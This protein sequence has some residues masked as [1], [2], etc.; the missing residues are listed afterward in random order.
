VAEVLR[1]VGPVRLLLE[2]DAKVEV[3]KRALRSTR[4]LHL[5]SHATFQP[6]NPRF[7]W[8]RLEDDRLTVADLYEVSLPLRP[9]VFMSACETGRG[10]AHGGG[11]L[12][13]SR[14]LLA[15][16]A[17]GL[18]VSLWKVADL[19]ASRLSADFYQALDPWQMSEGT[20]RALQQAQQAAISRHEHP[21]LWSAFIYV[22]G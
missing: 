1:R 12:G 7:S 4:L 22:Q 3:F 9:V 14:A 15:A 11:L 19:A 10:K 8:L 17:S 21:F 20:A 16:G 5:A 2:A 13:M 18:I 6:D